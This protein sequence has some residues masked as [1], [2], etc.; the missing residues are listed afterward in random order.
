MTDYAP[1]ERANASKLFLA[2]L[3]ICTFLSGSV[4]AQ[5]EETF[6]SGGTRPFQFPAEL[7][8]R[9]RIRLPSG[10]EVAVLDVREQNRQRTVLVRQDRER[11]FVHLSD[12]T[13]VRFD[14][15]KGGRF[16]TA[17]LFDVTTKDAQTGWIESAVPTYRPT[18]RNAP[19][20]PGVSSPTRN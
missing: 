20:V 16:Q 18:E 9:G 12:G 2:L 19:S 3:A 6:V 11:A 7:S 10:K 4:V 14:I 8:V 15:R 13:V 17:I 5:T 1:Y